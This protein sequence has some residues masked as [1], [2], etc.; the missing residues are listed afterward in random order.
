MKYILTKRCPDGQIVTVHLV[1]EE[2]LQFHLTGMW[3][4]TTGYEIISIVKA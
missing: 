3:N 1:S 4:Y 2:E